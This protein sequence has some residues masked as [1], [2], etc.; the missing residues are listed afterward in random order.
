MFTSSCTG[1]TL[2]LFTAARKAAELVSANLS[3]PRP[4]TAPASSAHYSIDSSYRPTRIRIR[5][6]IRVCHTHGPLTPTLNWPG[7]DWIGVGTRASTGIRTLPEIPGPV[8]ELASRSRS[9]TSHIAH[10]SGQSCS[11]KR[12][13][14][15]EAH[16]RL[17]RSDDSHMSYDAYIRAL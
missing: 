11:L 2:L 4:P 15:G 12:L 16:L 6:R 5:I 13:R 1:F 7:L 10:R 9:R 3:T 8:S 14:P 17:G